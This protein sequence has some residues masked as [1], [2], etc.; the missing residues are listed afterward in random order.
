VEVILLKGRSFWLVSIPQVCTWS[1]RKLLKLRDEARHFIKFSVGD[2]SKI[3][4]WFDD[5][6]PNGVLHSNYGPHVVY[7]AQSKLDP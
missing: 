6:H 5:W 3:H 2:G 4:M 7:D 1:W